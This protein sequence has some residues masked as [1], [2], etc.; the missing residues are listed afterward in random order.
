MDG[1]ECSDTGEA[2]EL[3][4]I[5]ITVNTLLGG[6]FVLEIDPSMLVS[7]KNPDEISLSYT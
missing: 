4:C 1:E 7:Q 6:M 3:S 2:P 5:T